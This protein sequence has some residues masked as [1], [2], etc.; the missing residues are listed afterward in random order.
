MWIWHNFYCNDFMMQL[1]QGCKW[2]KS[3]SASPHNAKYA[4]PFTAFGIRPYL[5]EEADDLAGDVLPSG[6]FV[7]HDTSRCGQNDIAEL[8]SWQQL[9][10]P[11]L[12][13]GQTD[14]VAGRDD[15]S[16]VETRQRG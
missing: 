14:V 8:T 13:I 16:L 1:I 15:T 11:L 7:I 4:R 6:L 3:P 12:E 10:D 5:V 9:D 2:Y